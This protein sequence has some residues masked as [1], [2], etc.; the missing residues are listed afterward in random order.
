VHL[1][2]ID[3]LIECEKQKNEPSVVFCFFRLSHKTKQRIIG[4]LFVLSFF[5][6]SQ[7]TEKPDQV[8]KTHP[9]L[10]IFDYLRVSY[11]DGH[12]FPDILST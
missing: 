7:K 5:S 1:S 3:F 6:F 2:A 4:R 8:E 10:Y 12:R 9:Y 11:A